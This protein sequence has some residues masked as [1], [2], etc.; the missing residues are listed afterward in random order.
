MNI[1]EAWFGGFTSFFSIW[2]FCLMQV[3]P[4]LFAFFVGFG[5]L[6]KGE[7]P[8]TVPWKRI[9]TL[10]VVTLAGF[11]VV[12]ISMGMI[13]TGVSRFLFRFLEMGNQ[14]GGVVI[15]LAGLYLLGVLTFREMPPA[16]LR[17]LFLA[18]GFLLGASLGLAYKPCVT[19]TLSVIINL[20]THADTAG[21]GGILLAFYTF[22]MAT[23][24]AGVGFAIAVLAW[25]LRAAAVKNFLARLC[26][27]LLVVVSI[28]MI[29]DHMTNYKSLLVGK[30]IPTHNHTHSEPH[31]GM[32]HE[33]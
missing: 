21:R 20:N 16:A 8:E 22:G 2:I 11:A 1:F 23:S 3:V 13:S 6:E 24:I 15:G 17:K 30:L 5:L 31:E 29:S 14:V 10:A 7:N 9:L 26:G 33:H 28:L 19:P 32:S 18:V 27:V 12:F 25:R 4:F